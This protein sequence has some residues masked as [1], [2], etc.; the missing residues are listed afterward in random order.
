MAAWEDC[1]HYTLQYMRIYVSVRVCVCVCLCTSIFR[2]NHS[3]VNQDARQRPSTD[4]PRLLKVVLANEDMKWK[5]LKENGKIKQMDNPNKMNIKIMPDRTYKERRAHAKLARERR[6]NENLMRQGNLRK[7]WIV[8]SGRLKLVPVTTQNADHTGNPTRNSPQ[9]H[10]EAT[11][12]ETPPTHRT[13][14]PAED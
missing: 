14:A 13:Q 2:I 8:V 7:K 1:K 4:R 3:R 6:E 12:L 5:I 9:Q 10:S 11:S